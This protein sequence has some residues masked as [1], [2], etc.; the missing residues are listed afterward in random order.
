MHRFCGQFL[1]YGIVHLNTNR[2]Q[3]YNIHLLKNL[4]SIVLNCIRLHM[5]FIYFIY[6]FFVCTALLIIIFRTG[7][8]V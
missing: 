3:S 4:G 6:I 2:I 5:F 1:P 7:G 8:A